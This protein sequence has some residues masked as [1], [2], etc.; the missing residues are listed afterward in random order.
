LL[1]LWTWSGYRLE[2]LD[3]LQCTSSAALCWSGYRPPYNPIA[4]QM[5][6]GRMPVPEDV[7]PPPPQNQPTRTVCHTQTPLP[8]N[9]PT[10][11]VNVTHRH[12]H[13]Y[14]IYYSTIRSTAT[15]DVNKIFGEIWPRFF[16]YVSE[17]TNK[18]Y[19]ALVQCWKVTEHIAAGSFIVNRLTTWVS[20][21]MS[22]K[23][24][25]NTRCNVR[26]QWVSDATKNES[27]VD[28]LGTD[29][30]MTFLFLPQWPL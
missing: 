11:T 18:Q 10:R 15:V 28:I 7:G 29:S 20:L 17:Q 1:N 26:C 19:F 24:V 27:L 3:R 23:V 8:Q 6:M 4:G 22:L 21:Q 13:L 2:W 30:C 5:P 16:K 25:C 14:V 12:H 9:Q